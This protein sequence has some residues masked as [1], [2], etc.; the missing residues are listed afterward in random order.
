[1]VIA[2]PSIGSVC[3]YSFE[4]RFSSLDGIYELTKVSSYDEM[5]SDGGDLVSSLYA[6]VGLAEADLN[7]DW[8]TYQDDRIMRL[9]N[10]D[11]TDVSILAP[12]AIMTMV[13]DPEIRAYDLLYMAINVGYHD[14]PEKLLWLRDHLRHLAGAVTGTL[15]DVSIH[16][17]KRVHMRIAD[18]NAAD[19]GRQA[20]ISTVQ[21]HIVTIQQLQTEID[22]LRGQVVALEELAAT[23]GAPS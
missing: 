20:R 3:A 9:V 19:L 17:S 1:M 2:P 16:S 23:L 6:L 5:L 22:R 21:P 7:V 8:T 12:T 18:Y 4:P 14:D 10:P 13:P 15:E 11:N